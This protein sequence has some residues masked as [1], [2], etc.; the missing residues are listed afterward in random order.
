MKENF[1][2]VMSH[3]LKHE[4]GFVD[5][6]QDPG[7]ATNLG[8]TMYTLAAYRG[9][10]V[11]DLPTSEVRNLKREEALEIYRKNYWNTCWCD[12]L[13]SGVDYAVMD[14]AVN[15]GVGR[16]I[17]TLQ[18]IVGVK[19]DG[20]FG[21]LTQGAVM[22]YGDYAKLIGII[23]DRRLSFLERLRHWDTFKNGWTRRVEGV[24]ADALTMVGLSGATQGSA[25]P[26]VQSSGATTT[27][28]TGESDR[29]I[30]EMAIALGI[31]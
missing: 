23:C 26:A 17:K 15:S 27:V 13:P 24:R 22:A 30:K 20:H 19:D 8:I 1:S 3:V 6:P 16:S 14:Y 31:W 2:Q 28:S 7:G 29:S 12:I 4:G 18:R 9:V 21:L 25:N 10:R 11:K 5:H